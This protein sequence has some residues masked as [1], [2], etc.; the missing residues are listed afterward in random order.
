MRIDAL[1]KPQGRWCEHCTTRRACDIYDIRPCECREF[2]C[3]YLTFSGLGDEWKPSK[4]K[5]VLVSELGGQ[6]LAAHV[7]PHT[8]DAWRRE[9]YH[10][11][12][13]NFATMAAQHHEHVIVCIGKRT[14]VILPDR[15][16]D[17][18]VV[19]DDDRIIVG[20]MHTPFGVKLEAYKMNKDDP[21]LRK[22]KED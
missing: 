6:R 22:Q 8:P 5:M 16:V 2:Y 21:R 3:G 13:R 10:S 17:L 15:D 7:H 12:L 19:D 4:S 11:Q 1:Q 14:F 9:P 18:G 20:E